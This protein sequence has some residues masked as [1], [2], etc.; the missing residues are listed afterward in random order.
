MS[1]SIWS[2]L[3]V[4]FFFVFFHHSQHKKDGRNKQNIYGNGRRMAEE[5]MKQYELRMSVEGN[6]YGTCDRRDSKSEY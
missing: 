1:F 5:E 3:A 4:D 2:V 6:L